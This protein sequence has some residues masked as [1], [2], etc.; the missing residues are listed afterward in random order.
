MAVAT[1]G[2]ATRLARRAEGAKQ[3][4]ARIDEALQLFELQ[5][6]RLTR[7]TDPL[8]EPRLDALLQSA[9]DR[10]HR[11]AREEQTGLFAA[12]KEQVR[13]SG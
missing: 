12:A 10:R 1:G 2:A 5:L 4:G 11:R 3:L 8:C 7:L 13:V 9:H 6:E